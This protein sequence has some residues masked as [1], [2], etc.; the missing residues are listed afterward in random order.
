[1]GKSPK[2]L[3]TATAQGASLGKS[4]VRQGIPDTVIPRTFALRCKS[5]V[6]P[7]CF[8]LPPKQVTGACRSNLA[9]TG[10]DKLPLQLI[11][12]RGSSQEHGNTCSEQPSPG[13]LRLMRLSHRRT[14]FSDGPSR[15]ASA[16]HSLSTIGP[17]SAAAYKHSS[18]GIGRFEQGSPTTMTMPQRPLFE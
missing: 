16:I 9:T 10:P 7:S 1:M 6:A 13:H 8:E 2:P 14:H 12:V 11:E 3:L 4:L 15:S 17:S 18:L 5:D